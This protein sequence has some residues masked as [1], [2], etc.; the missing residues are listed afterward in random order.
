MA[1]MSIDGAWRPPGRPKKGEAPHG[2]SLEHLLFRLRTKTKQMPSGCL[3]WTGSKIK[4]GYGVIRIGHAHLEYCHRLVWKL[5]A[6]GIPS[7]LHVL[8]HCDNP[9]C[10]R[11]D[12]LF[13]GTNTDNIRDRVRKG[14]SWLGPGKR[15]PPPNLQIEK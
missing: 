5:I 10:L 2:G 12:H 13:L 9:P 11:P 15:V 8:H 3:E 4:A 14:R 1:R 6:G 7:D